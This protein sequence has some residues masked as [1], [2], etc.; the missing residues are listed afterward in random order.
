MRKILAVVVVLALLAA[1]VWWFTRDGGLPGTSSAGSADSPLDFVPA[2]TPYV[3]ALLEPL[4][5]AERERWMSALD[6]MSAMWRMQIEVLRKKLGEDADVDAD[7]KRI[8]A[9][10]DAIEAEFAGKTFEAAA[11]DIGASM[12]GRS[13]L[14]GIGLAPVV[15]GELADPDKFRAAI[16]RIEQR[17]GETIPK[18]A[19][20]GIDYWY[21]DL[22]ETTLRVLLAIQGKHTVL[23]VGPS[24]DDAALRTLLGLD[25]PAKSLRDNGALQALNKQF[26]YHPLM[27]GYIDTVRVADLLT[28]ESSPVEAALLEAMKIEK[29][30]IDAT[31][32]T[33]A[34][35]LA[36]LMPRIS[37]GYTKLDGGHMDTVTRFETLPRIATDLMT[38]RTP[39]P[40]GA[41]PAGAILDFGIGLKA[42]ALPAL[43]NGWAD[44]A[45]TH[46]FTCPQLVDLNSTAE[47]FRTA[48]SNPGIYTVAPMASALRV[49]ATR[50]DMESLQSGTPDVSAKALIASDNPAALLSMAK[51]FAPDLASFDLKPDSAVV[52]LPTLASNPLPLP[53]F[54]AMSP[55]VLAL[56]VGED[57]QATLAGDLSLDP[58][59]QP[60]LVYGFDGMFYAQMMRFGMDRAALAATSDEEREEAQR[61]GQMMEDLYGKWLKHTTVTIGVD[62]HGLVFG[63]TMVMP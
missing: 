40:G 55:Q 47:Q 32:K 48:A 49:I 61:M 22:P 19:I 35:V 30:A 46:T 33:D 9:W 45:A 58:T 21:V 26:G 23:T 37:M 36:R 43:L 18:A 10:V 41:A 29:P 25:R 1:G 51:T 24:T 12:E 62:E 6:G 57:Q 27:S 60:L 3:I 63:Q 14:Y 2:D 52:P 20:D 11:A 38:L 8:L 56:G 42:A 34:Q 4:P 7:A 39:M 17:A 28:S 5:A 16:A 59:F 44:A 54:A 53:V 50:V 31:C 15:R 13:A